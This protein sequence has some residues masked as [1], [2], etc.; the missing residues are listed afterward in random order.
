MFFTGSYYSI[1]VIINV[2]YGLGNRHAHQR[3]PTFG[4]ASNAVVSPGVPSAPKDDFL[5][6]HITNRASLFRSRVS[7]LSYGRVIAGIAPVQSPILLAR[8]PRATGT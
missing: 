3:P 7:T 8:G 4:A 5:R 1:L 6:N 2:S